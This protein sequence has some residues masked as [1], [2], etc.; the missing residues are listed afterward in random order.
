VAR[1]DEQTVIAW[2]TGASMN[3]ARSAD[4]EL[5]AGDLNDL[6]L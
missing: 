2:H 1:C 4:T 6:R 5:V 3:P